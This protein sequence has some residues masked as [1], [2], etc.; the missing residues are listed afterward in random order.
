MLPEAPLL[1]SSAVVCLLSLY[2]VAKDKPITASSGISAPQA[3]EKETSIHP[4]TVRA[5]HVAF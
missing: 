5:R 2:E 4:R 1:D 3:P